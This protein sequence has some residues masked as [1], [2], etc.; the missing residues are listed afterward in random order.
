MK[1]NKHFS[2]LRRTFLAG[3][4]TSAA[5]TFLR[6]LVAQ[7]QAPTGSPQRLL[8][9]HRP[10]GTTMDKWWPTAGA[11]P[12]AWTASPLL[13]SF[14]KLR[15]KM[16]IVK[17]VDCPRVQS[18]LGDKHG[19]GMLA[20]VSPSPKDPGNNKAWPVLPGYTVAQQNDTNAKF[21]TATDKSIDQYLLEKIAALKGAKIPSVQ[22]TSSTES[23]DTKRD[24]CLRAV[25]YSKPV[26]TAPFPTALWP[27]VRPGTAFTTIFG[28]AMAGMSAGDLA[29]LQ[30]Q[31][32]SVL[33]YISKGLTGLKPR[34]PASEY[35]KIDANMTAI[36][37][38]E[39][40][41][42]SMG[43]GRQCVPPTLGALPT[44]PS[45]VSINDAQHFD[46][47][48]QHMNIIKTMFQC[49]I[50]RVASFTFGYGN[51]DLKFTNILPIAAKAGFTGAGSSLNNVD[52]HHN[53]SHDNG[54]DPPA[55]KYAIDKL[56]C[57]ITAK[58][59]LDMDAIPDGT[60]G[61]TLLDNTLVVFWNE[62]SDGNSHDT[63]DM[64]ILLFG[65]KF[66]NLQ[67]GKY[68]QFPK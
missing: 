24:S 34:L 36:S 56:Y 63:K 23:A 1:N 5:A 13:S 21:F 59:L 37:E 52:G 11:S 47:S 6:P 41:L 39:K 68:I 66:L 17:G 43:T 12:T 54:S 8:L 22:T 2:I 14:E 26:A 4:G 50:T 58:L 29:R 30:A 51:S 67:V 32:K 44:A 42:S 65:G 49:D 53:I 15:A 45:G 57:D 33:D 9:I 35:H 27:E 55:A 3:M 20:M 18:W 10:C 25:S 40:G 7:A 46:S 61:N 48:L 60:G 28:Q 16:T 19:A 38:L 64:P 62:C 31:N